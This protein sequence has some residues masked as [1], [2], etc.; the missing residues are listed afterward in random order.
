VAGIELV[1]VLR[2]LKGEISRREVLGHRRDF[3]TEEEEEVALTCGSHKSARERERQRVPVWFAYW[4]AGHFGCWAESLPG[5][6]L[7]FFLSFFFFFFYFLISFINFANLDQ[8]AS[9]QF[10]KVSKIPINIPEQ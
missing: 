4:A 3:R 8:I 10:C 2:R 7:Y 9:N 5:A 6:L 1:K